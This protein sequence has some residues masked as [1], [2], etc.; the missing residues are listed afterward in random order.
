MVEW[1]SW[2]GTLCSAQARAAE[3]ARRAALS[4]TLGRT[5]VRWC[6]IRGR[7]ADYV[8][9]VVQICTTDV[10]P[11]SGLQGHMRNNAEGLA[12][13]GRDALARERRRGAWREERAQQLAQDVMLMEPRSLLEA[14]ARVATTDSDMRA[15]VKRELAVH[16][17]ESQTSSG[18]GTAFT[19]C[20]GHLSRP[21]I[22]D[23][24]NWARVMI[25]AVGR[26]DVPE[27]RIMLPE[28]N[29][30]KQLED[31]TEESVSGDIAAP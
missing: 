29:L 24:L 5:S 23:N 10:D 1:Q 18:S 25:W 7:S 3:R 31:I 14:C 15:R 26:Q 17:D 13:D 8:P 9:R 4:R 11:I 21:D 16:F 6:A 22:V 27:I 19:H 2:P 20:A 12:A 30:D 28:S